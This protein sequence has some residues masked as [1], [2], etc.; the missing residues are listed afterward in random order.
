MSEIFRTFYG[1]FGKIAKK[2]VVFPNSC[3]EKPREHRILK[4][5]FDMLD[6]GDGVSGPLMYV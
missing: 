3:I 2:P 4:G 1:G 5:E 6:L